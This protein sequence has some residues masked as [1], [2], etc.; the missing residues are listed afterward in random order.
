MFQKREG[1]KENNQN[2]K[3]KMKL[4]CTGLCWLHRPKVWGGAACHM[5]EASWVMHGCCGRDPAILPQVPEHTQR[6]W[7]HCSTLSLRG[8][9]HRQI[10]SIDP[11]V[12]YIGRKKCSVLFGLADLEVIVSLPMMGGYSLW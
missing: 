3:I 7:Q 5:D 2:Q 11:G 10:G 6:P 8:L 4:T 9:K 12:A 1:V